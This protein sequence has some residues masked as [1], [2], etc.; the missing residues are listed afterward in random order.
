MG[1]EKMIPAEDD[2]SELYNLLAS[3]KACVYL[4]V[5]CIYV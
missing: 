1:K 4:Y 2:N 3:Q 5:W